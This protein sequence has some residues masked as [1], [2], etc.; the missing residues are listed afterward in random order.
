MRSRFL[1]LAVI[2]FGLL[3]PS[4]QAE[5][6]TLSYRAAKKTAQRKGDQ[7]AGKRARVSTL[8]RQSRHRYYAQAKWTR[9][10]PTGCK[11]C[12]YDESTGQFY[13]TP[14]TEYCWAELTVRFRSKRSRRVVAIL[15]SKS[16]S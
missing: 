7:V 9:T 11:G 1:A 3:G 15:E 12:G 2:A 5:A 8:I 4:S 6:H 14:S 16:C 13:D 10:D